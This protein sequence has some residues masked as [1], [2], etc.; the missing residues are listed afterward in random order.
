M[1]LNKIYIE[2]FLS[3]KQAEIDFNEFGNIT[4]VIGENQDTS[5]TTSNGA[6]KSSIIEAVVFALFGKTLRKTNEK[7]ITNYHT[8]G[9]CVVRL[10]VND[11]VI[12]ER[13]KKPPRLT[14]EIAGETYTQDSIS[15]TQKY[16]ENTLNTNHSIFTAS[17]VFG[18]ANTMDFLTATAEE[19]RAIIQSFLSVGDLFRNRAAIRS[20]KSQAL[21]AKKVAEALMN[22]AQMD[23]NQMSSKLKAV[24]KN[25]RRAADLLSGDTKKFIAKYTV[26]EIAALESQRSDIERSIMEKEHGLQMSKMSISEYKRR[27]KN[28]P[29]KCEKCDWISQDQ[30]DLKEED[31]KELEKWIKSAK[32]I[33]GELKVLTKEI[34]KIRIPIS[35][36]DLETVENYKD[37]LRDEEFYKD[38]IKSKKESVDAHGQEVLRHQKQYDIMKF[39]ETAF[40]EAGIIKYIIRNILEFFNERCNFYMFSLSQ[41][42]FS[43]KFDDSLEEEIFNDG[44]PCFFDS[45]S[46]GEKKRVS[47]AVMLAL[48][49][50]L[51]L[52]GKERSNIVFFDEVADTL[53]A[54]GVVSLFEVLK[55]LSQEKKVFIITH[56]DEFVSLLQ[57]EAENFI[58]KKKNKI[59]TFHR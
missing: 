47:L 45:M 3:I 33:E 48:N 42:R 35:A 58:V 28:D 5:P 27:V 52:T 10:T 57:N 44:E 1:K 22:S 49:D 31:K 29:F 16:M 9:K 24:Q 13:T 54:Q 53:D 32:R 17:M 50:L 46:G 21:S 34:D 37:S 36:H 55:E 41:G 25:R 12:I 56:N 15:E 6:G 11:N 30:W 59:T 26:P 18:Q 14:L 51:L 4:H 39:W 19:K 43:I 20:L 38:R 23:V 2:N 8:K 40:S 7:S